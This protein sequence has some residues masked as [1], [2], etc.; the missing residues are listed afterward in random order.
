MEK[1]NKKTQPSEIHAQH[2]EKRKK[3]SK[4]SNCTVA[5]LVAP[6][7]HPQL[8]DERARPQHDGPIAQSSRV[9]AAPTASPRP[10][11]HLSGSVGDS[12]RASPSIDALPSLA[13]LAS[14]GDDIGTA[15]GRENQTHAVAPPPPSASASLL[16]PR[17][18]P[19]KFASLVS[20]V[21]AVQCVRPFCFCEVRGSLLI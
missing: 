11:T 5:P 15:F 17:V 12:A 7:C 14:R 20:A 9:P 19:I 18:L 6:P 1:T 21:R 16:W 10:A 3:S 13:E 4:Q 8:G 2:R